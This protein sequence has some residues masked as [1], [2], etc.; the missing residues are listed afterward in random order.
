MLRTSVADLLADSEHLLAECFGPVSLVAEYD[1]EIQLIEAADGLEGQLTASVHAEPDDAIIPGLL[2]KLADKAGRVLWNGWPT[3]VSVTWAMQHGGP[4]PATTSPLHT[5]V[6]AA[7]ID[8]F[9]R[10]VSYQSI[11]EHL[12]PTALRDENALG[13]PRRI[14]GTLFPSAAKQ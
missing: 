10:P 8:R 12:L 9:L 4:Y 2:D 13:L 1:E 7:A 6:G 11:P 14:D 3:G 5:S